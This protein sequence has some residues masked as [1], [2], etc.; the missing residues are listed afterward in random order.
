M[1]ELVPDRVLAAALAGEAEHA[2]RINGI[3][4]HV[5]LLVT[6]V[7]GTPPVEVG[8]WAGHGALRTLVGMSRVYPYTAV[9]NHTG[10]PAASVPAGFTDTGLP[11][12]VM[13]IAPPHREDRLLSVAAQLE[14]ALD[15]PAH[16]PPEFVDRCT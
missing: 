4:D 10:Q 13:L 2:A 14:A 1:G 12:G 8:H 6:P 11:V 15:W 3:F 16:R 7:A 9:W 5:D